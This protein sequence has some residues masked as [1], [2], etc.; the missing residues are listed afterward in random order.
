MATRRKKCSVCGRRRSI[1]M[2]DE[3]KTSPDGY[4]AMCK[5]CRKVRLD[6]YRRSEKGIENEQR[7]V[8]STRKR[9]LV[10]EG[11][12]QRRRD[13]VNR[14]SDRPEY[15]ERLREKQKTP[16]GLKAKRAS[17]AV[18]RAIARG[19]I[20]R[21]DACEICGDKPGEDKRGRSKVRAWHHKGYD[22]EYKLDVKFVCPRCL[23]RIKAGV[24]PM[25]DR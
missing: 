20:V 12:A 25:A 19:D 14:S 15:R 6:E 8:V 17:G 1:H 10:D 23:N 4:R 11:Y 2:F 22:E 24:D 13:I 3:D 7:Y 9:R 5:E 16:H 18:D 21:P